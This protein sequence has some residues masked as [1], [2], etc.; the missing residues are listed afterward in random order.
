MSGSMM[1]PA[2][3]AIGKDLNMGDAETQLTLSIFALAFAF[4]LLFSLL[5]LKSSG[6]GLFGYWSAC[7][8]YFGIQFVALLT[9]RL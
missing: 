1:A 6:E 5:S 7:G 9:Q 4:P 8:T 3:S 2:L